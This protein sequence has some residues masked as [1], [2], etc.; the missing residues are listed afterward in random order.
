MPG[1]TPD[2]VNAGRTE[3]LDKMLQSPFEWCPPAIHVVQLPPGLQDLGLVPRESTSASGQ[4]CASALQQ[5]HFVANQTGLLFRF[6][7]LFMGIFMTCR[8][9]AQPSIVCHH[10]RLCSS[11]LHPVPTVYRW[12]QLP[13]K[14]YLMCA[15]M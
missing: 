12:L 14:L 9:A 7:C 15:C 8:V 11:L 10:G 6:E 5:Y 4:W 1:R 2:A 3:G 13:P